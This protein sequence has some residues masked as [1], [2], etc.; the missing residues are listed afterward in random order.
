L[1]LQPE[2][3]CGG[4]IFCSNMTRAEA[5]ILLKN[6]LTNVNLI[7]HSLA[8]ESAMRFLANRFDKDEEEWGLT[9]L[10]HDI[11]YEEVKGDP[12]QHSLV[13]AEILE[14]AGLDSEIVEAVKTHNEFHQLPPKSLMAKALF[15]ADPLTGLIIANALVLPSHKIQDLTID[16]VLKHFHQSSFAKGVKREIIA[17][18]EDYLHLG[19]SEF[20]DIVLRSMQS[21]NQEL[22]L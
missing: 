8:V 13:G 14:K 9:G 18:C 4:L 17:R 12:G 6:H 1:R 5:L 16:S 19:L 7:K 3:L 15:C 22:G 2:S 21:I 20:I 11:D 10:L